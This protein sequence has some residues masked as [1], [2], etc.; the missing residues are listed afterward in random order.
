MGKRYLVV[1]LENNWFAINI[2]NFED[3][4]RGIPDFEED[5]FLITHQTSDLTRELKSEKRG[6]LPNI[7]DLESFDKQMS[8]KGRDLKS[9]DWTL[10]KF[11]KEHSQIESRFRLSKSSLKEFLENLSNLFLSLEGKN[12][13]ERQRFESI[14]LKINKIIYER[15]VNGINVNTTLVKE[16]CQEL[17]KRIYEIKNILQLQYNILNS[18]S[19]LIQEEYLNEKNFKIIQSVKHSFRSYR[20][21]DYVCGLFYEMNRLKSDLDS[22][23]MISARW[24]SVNKTYPIY[25]GFGTITSRITLK[26]PA[27]QGLRKANRDIVTPSSGKK[28]LYVDYSQFEAGILASLSK[29]QKL[30]ELYNSDIYTDLAT[31]ILDDTTKRNEAKTIFYRFM[32]GDTS[33]FKFYKKSEEY[34]NKFTSLISFKENVQKKLIEEG[35]IGT[36]NGNYRISIDPKDS[37]ALSHI[38]QATASL[39]YKKALINV[40][41]AIPKADFLIPMHDATLYEIDNFRFEE[42]KNK[43]IAAYQAEFKKVCPEVEARV[44][45]EDFF[46]PEIHV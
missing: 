5:D 22:L 45:C 36:T 33:L 27:L 34:F 17:E 3:H 44:N 29:D 19:E 32:Y 40:D 41:L 11:L 31:Q 4:Q 39:I 26:E 10:F 24:G 14:E 13:E 28:L 8:Q 7:I 15:Q 35:K 30:I 25:K 23:L 12:A 37:W 43:I 38:V 18:D 42:E 16:R 6:I 21:N 46:K 2:D 9:G 20:Y 1:F